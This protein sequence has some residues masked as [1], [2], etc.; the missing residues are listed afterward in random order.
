MLIQDMTVDLTEAL[1]AMWEENASRLPDA[2]RPP[3][4]MESFLFEDGGLTQLHI[5]DDSPTVVVVGDIQPG[6]NASVL[7]LGHENSDIGSLLR[8]MRNIIDEL[9]LKRL[10]ANVPAPVKDVQRT[11]VNVGF[12]K[13]GH[14]RRSI[15]YDGRLV[16]QDIYGMYRDPPREARRPKDVKHEEKQEAVSVA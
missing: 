8:E 16:G 12:R 11:L 6:L 13:E 14:L 1:L 10:T 15:Y 7:L 5:V 9:E 2:L 4:V 3:A